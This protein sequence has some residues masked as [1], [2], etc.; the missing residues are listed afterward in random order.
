M[1]SVVSYGAS[2]EVPATYLFSLPVTITTEID[3]IPARILAYRL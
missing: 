1:I 2:T 3:C